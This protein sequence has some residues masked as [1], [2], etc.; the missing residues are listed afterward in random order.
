MHAW[1]E[2]SPKMFVVQ[3]TQFWGWWLPAAG[4][5][6]DCEAMNANATFA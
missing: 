1:H 4:F 6:V 5:C 2:Q 3:G